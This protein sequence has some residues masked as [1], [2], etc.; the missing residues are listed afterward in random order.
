MLHVTLRNARPHESAAVEERLV[1]SG[2]FIKR[3]RNP[4]NE[5]MLAKVGAGE[6]AAV[7]ALLEAMPGVERVV[8]IK[9]RYV[10]SARAA[11][12]DRTVVRITDE[13]SIGGTEV[14]VIGGPCSVESHEQ[15][16]SVAL[17]VKSAGA[18]ALRGGAF[19]PRTSPFSFQGLEEDGLDILE[20]VRSE[21]GLPVVSELM[22]VRKLEAMDR[23]VDV[24]QIGMRNA[25]NY[26]LLKEV[27]ALASRR[28]VL[29][30]CGIGTSLEEFLCAADYVLAEGN[31]NVILCLRGTVGISQESRC[32]MNIVDVS[33]LRRMTHLPIVVDPSH[34]AGRWEFVPSVAAAALVAG[35]DGLLVEVHD[36]PEDALSDAEQ[37]LKPERFHQ[38]MHR[39]R[40]LA[41]V[42]GR[43]V[44]ECETP[45]CVPDGHPLEELCL[46]APPKN[47]EPR[48]AR[49]GHAGPARLVAGA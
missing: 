2:R 40:L 11:V 1:A 38:M 4:D 18:R 36:H 12:A 33:A 10:L 8:D 15:T 32:S 43:T 44:A 19:K 39:L 46:E 26:P 20:R 17:A 35:A 7:T 45:V 5:V 27:G 31:P 6:V 48:A 16:S 49:H 28:P 29:L 9:S 22:S 34:V 37:S 24:I 13:L 21:T 47:G 23:A 25:L 41:P 3:I 42:L 14:V 30:K